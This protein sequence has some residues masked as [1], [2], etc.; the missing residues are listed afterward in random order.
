MSV[1]PFFLFI[2]DPP[3]NEKSGP[4]PEVLTAQRGDCQGEPSDKFSVSLVRKG[5]GCVPVRRG[6]E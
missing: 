6:V 4:K 3:I 1:K 2:I 5:T